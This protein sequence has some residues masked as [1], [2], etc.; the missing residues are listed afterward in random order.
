MSTAPEA[1]ASTETPLARARGLG[2]AGEGAD[3]WWQERLTSIATL[4]L[5]VWL[6]VSLVRLPDLDWATL[7]EWLAQPLAAAP[8]LLLV[9]AIFW[10]ARLG[11]KVVLEDYVH[12]EG[13]KLFWLLL[14]D[15]A[16]IFAAAV[17]LFAILKVAL[18]GDG[19]G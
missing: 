7:A 8:M 15:F 5:L 12:G 9:V 13:G 14:I 18:G 1:A 6:A 19:A 16:A 10:H 11:L 17:G 4:L 2:A 3:T